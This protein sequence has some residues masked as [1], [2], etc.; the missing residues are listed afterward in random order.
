VGNDV[1]R[2]Y[3]YRFGRLAPDPNLCLM[4]PDLCL[5]TPPFTNSPFS[6]LEAKHCCSNHMKTGWR[7]ATFW[8]FGCWALLLRRSRETG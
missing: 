1:F 3:V 2:S 5:Q 4:P 8:R 7:I 6:R